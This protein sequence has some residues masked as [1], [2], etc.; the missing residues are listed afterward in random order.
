MTWNDEFSRNRTRLSASGRHSQMCFDVSINWR[1]LEASDR[2]REMHIVAEGRAVHLEHQRG[3]TAVYPR[4]ERVPRH[5]NN[6]NLSAIPSAMEVIVVA[7]VSVRTTVARGFVFES[8]NRVRWVPVRVQVAAGGTASKRCY[9]ATRW[10]LVERWVWPVDHGRVITSRMDHYTRIHRVA[11]PCLRRRLLLPDRHSNLRHQPQR[12][13]PDWANDGVPL[14]ILIRNH[15]WQTGE[16]GGEKGAMM[17]L[18]GFWRINLFLCNVV[19]V[20]F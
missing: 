1:E 15:R 14:E 6:S 10:V 2:R 5:N 16:K 3:R 7:A 18:F 17:S 19:V 20:P 9:G 8:L 11:V 13:S 12:R 4:V